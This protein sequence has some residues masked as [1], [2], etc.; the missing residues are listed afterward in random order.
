MNNF[1]CATVGTGKGVPMK[2][3][4]PVSQPSGSVGVTSKAAQE[5][6]WDTQLWEA[7]SKSCGCGQQH[8]LLM[9]QLCGSVFPSVFLGDKNAQPALYREMW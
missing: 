2:H 9:S 3:P 6:G 8:Y 1:Y 5:G 7:Q 4:P